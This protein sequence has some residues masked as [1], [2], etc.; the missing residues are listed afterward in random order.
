MSNDQNEVVGSVES[1]TE[2]V[3][4]SVVSSSNGEL[5]IPINSDTV[6]SAIESVLSNDQGVQEEQELTA[7]DKLKLANYLVY[8]ILKKAKDWVEDIQLYAKFNPNA[9]DEELVNIYTQ[10]NEF[11]AAANN[12]V[13]ETL[14]VKNYDPV[15]VQVVV[16]SD[17]TTEE[18]TDQPQS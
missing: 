2:G 6:N 11:T 16:S 4:S 12:I 17:E 10:L 1:I 9:I 18:S 7:E 8:D 14:D 5:N 13:G 3:S 15:K